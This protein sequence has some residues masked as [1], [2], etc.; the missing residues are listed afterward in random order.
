MFGDPIGGLLGWASPRA[1]RLLL[2]V[3][4]VLAG[5]VPGAVQ[6]QFTEIPVPK[7]ME[8]LAFMEGDWSVEGSFRTPDVVGDDRRIWYRTRDGGVTGFDGR[9][10]SAFE[11]GTPTA[12]S[13][14]RLAKSPA[15][16][17]EWVN[18]LSVWAIQDDF[19]MLADEGRTSGTTSFFYDA[20][21]N[22][23]VALAIHA[24][25]GAV[26]RSRA[27]RSD[28]QL[29]FTGTGTDRR[30][31]RIFVRAY[32]L[33]DADHYRIRTNVSFDGGTTWID[34]QILQEVR[35]R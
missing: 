2:A 28:G 31:E 20:E 18:E 6:G 16:P 24:P 35:R 17:F 29:V 13:V 30:G 23:W 22:Q 25:T 10:W 4:V 9:S 15:E 1:M 12:D 21:A 14:L 19:V 7:E 34:D 5:S 8:R 11:A 26:T 3:A 33:E 27:P 32:E